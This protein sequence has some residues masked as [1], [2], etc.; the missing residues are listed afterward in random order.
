MLRE[1]K[2]INMQAEKEEQSY[3]RGGGSK[4][5]KKTATY[6]EKGSVGQDDRR[7]GEDIKVTK[8]AKNSNSFKPGSLKPAKLTK[9]K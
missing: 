7:G 9:Q 3:L 2:A 5:S 4:I 1:E 8:L 6:Q